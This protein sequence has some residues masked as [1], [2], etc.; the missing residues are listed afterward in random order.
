MFDDV[1]HY[2]TKYLSPPTADYHFYDELDDSICHGLGE[3]TLG[4]EEDAPSILFPNEVEIV[5]EL[6]ATIID[7]PLAISTTDLLLTDPAQ[8]EIETE[9]VVFG[10]G[11]IGLSTDGIDLLLDPILSS[12][13]STKGDTDNTI[14]NHTY[15]VDDGIY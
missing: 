1:Q 11:L 3:L 4:N 5:T 9:N 10:P 13:H 15:S 6:Q 14:T 12:D 7:P 2:A 8:L